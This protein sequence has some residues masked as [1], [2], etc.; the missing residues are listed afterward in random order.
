MADVEPSVSVERSRFMMALAFASVWVPIERIAVTTAGRPVG[1]AA[2]AKA[3]AARKTVLKLSPRDMLSA[4]EMT[5]AVPEMTRI[6][7][8]SLLSCF[9]SGEAA[10]SS[11]ESMFEMWP[12]SVDIPVVVT[13]SSPA[14]L[15]TL[16]FM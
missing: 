16:V 8:V 14:P 10:S 11:W 3:I 6:W 1:I 15:V 9:V 5:S 13:T 4:I 12:T 7:L 2:I